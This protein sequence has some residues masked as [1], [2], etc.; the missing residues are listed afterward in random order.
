MFAE[1]QDTFYLP[2]I[3]LFMNIDCLW[4]LSTFVS[5]VACFTTKLLHPLPNVHMGMSMS[6]IQKAVWKV[7]CSDPASTA[8]SRGCLRVTGRKICNF[9]S[10]LISHKAPCPRIIQAAHMCIFFI[11]FTDHYKIH[12]RL[13][14]PNNVQIFYH[15]VKTFG[16][17]NTIYT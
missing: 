17:H 15:I 3:N 2:I 12:F 5:M 14:G 10:Q 16:P 11:T 7:V 13:W 9:H 1:E 6:V 4:Y 8:K